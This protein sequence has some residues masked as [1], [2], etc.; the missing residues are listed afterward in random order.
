MT[1][2]CG[3]GSG[4]MLCYPARIYGDSQTNLY[5]ADNNGIYLWPLG[6]SVSTFISGANVS[7]IGNV[8]GLFVDNNQN[9]YASVSSAS[10]YSVMMWT[11][12]ATAGT[13]VAG[14]TSGGYSLSSLYFPQGL[15][16]DSL[17]NTIYVANYDTE[18]II[19]WK[20]GATSGT[21][22]AGQNG[23]IGASNSLL[24]YPRD[25]KRDSNGNLYVLDSLNYRVLLFCQS[26]PSTTGISIADI[27]S[28]TLPSIA[29]D[30]NL[31]VYVVDYSYHR[32]LK[33]NR[34]V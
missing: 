30:S 34:I 17:T 7:T 9:L 25:V 15:T 32:I 8:Y 24:R 22:V 20:L 13:I 26:P 5:I 10:G 2:M 11:S 19:A 33:F 6:L 14:G 21:I 27:G 28:T 4:G 23:T 29:L 31:N 12:G 1:G 18:T 3:L 16:V